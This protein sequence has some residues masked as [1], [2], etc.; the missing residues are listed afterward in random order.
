MA[1]P[2]PT[3]STDVVKQKVGVAPT[4]TY[5]LE[6]HNILKQSAIINNSSVLW[7]TL[8]PFLLDQKFVVLTVLFFHLTHTP[9]RPPSSRTD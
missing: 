5:H 1:V 2:M 6:L 4:H 3:Q 9:F 7:G 8:H